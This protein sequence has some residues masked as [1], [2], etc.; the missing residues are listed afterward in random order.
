MMAV[1]VAEE[2]VVVTPVVVEAEPAAAMILLTATMARFHL[3]EAIILWHR[4]TVTGVVVVD[5]N[6][7]KMNHL[8]DHSMQKDMSRRPHRSIPG[9]SKHSHYKHFLHGVITMQ[10]I[11]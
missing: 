4:V 3:R 6:P 7:S 2:L 10:I 8:L 11:L 1:A 9:I 5:G